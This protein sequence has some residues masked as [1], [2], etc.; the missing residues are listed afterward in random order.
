[1]TIDTNTVVS[2]SEANQN[3]SKVCRM[4]DNLGKAVIFKNNSPKY[5]VLEFSV[6]ERAEASFG[7]A[8]SEGNTSYVPASDEEVKTIS[9]QLMEQNDAAYKELAK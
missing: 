5:I 6:A 2:I 1:M 8:L 3:F 4:V 9:A 7:N